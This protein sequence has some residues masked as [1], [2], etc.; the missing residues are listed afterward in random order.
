[1]EM[2]DWIIVAAC[3]FGLS[4]VTFR[5]LRY[6]KGASVEKVRL[7]DLSIAPCNACEACLKSVEAPC[8]IDDDM[9]PL[10]KKIRSAEG[11]VF[12]S[13]FIL[14]QIWAFVSPGLYRSEKRAL[15]P[16]FTI[17]VYFDDLVDGFHESND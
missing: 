15:I 5:S 13:P 11:L 3:L 17:G 1:M 9:G 14:S 16:V 12:A 4:Y 2:I 8:V 7:H 10:L 6:M